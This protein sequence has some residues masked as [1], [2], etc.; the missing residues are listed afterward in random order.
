MFAIGAGTAQIAGRRTVKD[1]LRRV[2]GRVFG[3]P[4]SEAV[5]LARPALALQLLPALREE[6]R[7]VGAMDQHRLAP[8]YDW[9][10]LGNPTPYGVLMH[11]EG[12]RDLLDR[13]G[14]MALR[15]PGI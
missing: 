14:A 4:A 13:V 9:Q 11:A 12:A 2:T 8:V 5:D 1:A 10:S 15:E 7:Q 6:R 3:R